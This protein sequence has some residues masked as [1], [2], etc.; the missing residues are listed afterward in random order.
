MIKFPKMHIAASVTNRILN[1]MD[2]LEE[3]KGP[4]TPITP[5]SIPE[6]DTSGDA[7]EVKLATPPGPVSAP[8]ELAMQDVL[9][10]GSI[11]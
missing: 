4:E 1:V 11:L 5:P 10:P 2:E 7:I 8:P 3:K 6:P 9:G